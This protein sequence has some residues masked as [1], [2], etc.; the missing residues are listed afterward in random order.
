[1]TGLEAQLVRTFDG[2]GAFLAALAVAI[3]VGAAHGLGPGHGKTIAAGYL[4][5]TRA[6]LRT[7]AALAVLVAAM[8]TVSVLVLGLV[9]WLVLGT[10]ALPID[11]LTRW[12]QLGVALVVVALG[13]LIARR[14]WGELRSGV[15]HHHAARPWSWPGLVAT[16]SAGGLLPSPAAFLILVSG[17]LTG[18]AAI[19]VAMVAAFGLGLAA[20]VLAVGALA[21]SGRDW[22]ARSP[23]VL[24]RRL[25]ALAPAAGT[26]AVLAGGC[27][28]AGVAVAGLVA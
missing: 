6:G 28:L 1:M 2:G 25:V 22:L 3:A 18:R 12:A 20:T 9:W 15:R 24:P 7:A 8:H 23:R 26:V 17:L 16:A 4:V 13:V 11:T 14:R 21:V 19:A 10:A 5:G 27:L